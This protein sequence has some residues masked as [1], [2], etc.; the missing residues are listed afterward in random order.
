MDRR[1]RADESIGRDMRQSTCQ[2][3]ESLSVSRWQFTRLS[4]HWSSVAQAILQERAH[5]ADTTYS[6]KTREIFMSEDKA[7]ITLKLTPEQQEQVRQATG[8][9]GDTLEL[10]IEE[11]EQRIAPGRIRFFCY[12]RDAHSSSTVWAS[13][14]RRDG[15][16]GLRSRDHTSKAPQ[17]RGSARLQTIAG[18][19]LEPATPAL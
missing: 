4:R 17:L 1:G 5:S 12:F 16:E 9:L 2:L 15:G 6:R 19:G 18:A 13:L 10:S 11:L 8:K 3:G 7:S 14:R